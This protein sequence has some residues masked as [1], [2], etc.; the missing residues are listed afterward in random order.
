MNTVL[1]LSVIA[2][3]VVGTLVALPFLFAL[4]HVVPFWLRRRGAERLPS[5]TR[6]LHLGMSVAPRGLAFDA[7]VAAESAGLEL[8]PRWPLNHLHAGGN[9]YQVVVALATAR[10]RGDDVSLAR[11]AALDLTGHDPVAAAERG[12]YHPDI[13]HGPA[14]DALR[15]A[16]FPGLGAA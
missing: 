15:D 7:A 3:F 11:L 2:A 4:L 13:P 9:P 8:D 12:D 5:F 10:N 6:L 16:G 14:R 1:S